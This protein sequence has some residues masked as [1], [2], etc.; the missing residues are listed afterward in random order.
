MGVDDNNTYYFAFSRN[1]A[2]SLVTV[3]NIRCHT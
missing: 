2:I 3:A 1:G